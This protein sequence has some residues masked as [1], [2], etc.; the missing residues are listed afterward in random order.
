MRGL[1]RPG[2]QKRPQW[3]SADPPYYSSDELLLALADFD[4]RTRWPGSRSTQGGRSHLP[5]LSKA[6]KEERLRK[7]RQAWHMRVVD[8]RALLE[9]AEELGVSRSVV[10]RWL[11]GVPR[12]TQPP[13]D[14]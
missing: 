10:G 3:W 11:K 6:A 1:R 2:R 4:D 12:V 8:G 5:Q 13:P 9:I 7:A 14:Q